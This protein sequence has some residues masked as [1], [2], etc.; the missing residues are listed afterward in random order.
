[1]TP[2]EEKL[3]IAIGVVAFAVATWILVSQCPTW[4]F[5]GLLLSTFALAASAGVWAATR[6]EEE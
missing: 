6:N 1:M 5:V 2:S 4:W 3:F